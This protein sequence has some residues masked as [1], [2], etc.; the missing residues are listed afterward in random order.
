MKKIKTLASMLMILVLLMNLAACGGGGGSTPTATPT[1]TPAPNTGGDSGDSDIVEDDDVLYVE[2]DLDALY[3]NLDYS[4]DGYTD[5]GV[6]VGFAYNEAENFGMILI[7]DEEAMEYV[8]FVGEAEFDETYVTIYDDVSNVDFTVEFWV[9]DD[10]IYMIDL[11]EE[12]GV[13]EVE[14]IA[15]EDLIASLEYAVLEA[16]LVA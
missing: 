7:L 14:Q 12:F 2:Y 11:G 16:D 15:V 8:A 3:D 13:A 10:E 9:E 1:A 4:F 6:Y 5:V